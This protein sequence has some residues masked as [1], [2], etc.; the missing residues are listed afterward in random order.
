VTLIYLPLPLA[1]IIVIKLRNKPLEAF[2]L[3]SVGMPDGAF[4]TIAI[5]R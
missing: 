4:K 5:I 1:R 2:S 3:C